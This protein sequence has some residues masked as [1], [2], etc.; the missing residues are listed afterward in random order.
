MF[1]H[2]TDGVFPDALAEALISAILAPLLRRSFG[3]GGFSLFL[4]PNRGLLE[5]RLPMLKFVCQAAPAVLEKENAGLKNK[6][7]QI[8]KKF[9]KV[10]LRDSFLS[11]GNNFAS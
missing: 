11:I 9:V 6:S 10:S 3:E 2:D 1:Q 5:V 7:Y 8:T 4:S